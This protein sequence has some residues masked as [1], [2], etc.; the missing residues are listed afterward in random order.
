MTTDVQLNEK[1]HET[2]LVLANAAEL[3]AALVKRV[4]GNDVSTALNGTALTRE[5]IQ[6]LLVRKLAERLK[7][8][9]AGA[10]C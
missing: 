2:A 10:M 6:N 4:A 3:G 8:R 7:K 9:Q 1:Q 5:M